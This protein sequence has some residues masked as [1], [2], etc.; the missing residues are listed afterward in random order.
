MYCLAIWIQNRVFF[1]IFFPPVKTSGEGFLSDKNERADVNNDFKR[2]L[3]KIY[4]L[5]DCSKYVQ[6]LV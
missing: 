6:V 3:F 4:L 1:Y 5:D 2:V